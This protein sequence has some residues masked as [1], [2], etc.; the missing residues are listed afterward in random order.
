M[1]SDS[2][3]LIEEDF[4]YLKKQLEWCID[5]VKIKKEEYADQTEKDFLPDW[6]PFRTVQN[7][8][9]VILN[10]SLTENSVAIAAL[11]INILN[12]VFSDLCSD[13]PWDK[14]LLI[15]GARRA[16]Q[17]FLFDLFEEIYSI[18]QKD[19][20]NKN[21]ADKLW[22]AYSKFE[23][24]Y[25]KELCNLNKEDQKVINEIIMNMK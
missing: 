22:R 2:E 18:L 23:F 19:S 15:N 16:T 3:N 12:R 1:I 20:E 24:K 8:L 14:D 11:I 10:D 21:S 5:Q 17:R 4:L 7:N 9:N 6:S 25:N 13:T